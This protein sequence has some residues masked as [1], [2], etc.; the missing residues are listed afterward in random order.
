MRSISPIR[1]LI[2]ILLFIC[3]PDNV[4][5]QASC[6]SP[7]TITP[8]TTCITNTSSRNENIKNATSTSPTGSC[9]GATATT[10]YGEWFIF[11]PVASTATITLSGLGSSLSAATTYIELLTGTC[12]SFT[13]ICQNAS[14]SLNATGLIVGTPYYVRVYVTTN[15]NNG[16]SPNQYDYTICITSPPANDECSGAVSL[17]SNTSCSNTAGSFTMITASTGLP[18]GCEPA[19]T[20]Y[21]LWYSFVAA[22]STHTVTLSSFTAGNPALQLYSGSCGSLTSLACGTTTVSSTSLTA[23]ATYYIRVSNVGT[24]PGSATFNICVTNPSIITGDECT[25]AIN[26]TSNSG[27]INTS[28]TLIGATASSGIPTGC[29][30]AG[31]H[32]DVWF[33][34][35]A[36]RT[37]HTISFTKKNPSNISNSELQ[38]FSGTCGSLTSLQC[39]TTSIAATGLTIATTYYVRVS[40]VGGSALT[41]R[42]DFDICVTHAATAP[43]TIDYSKSYVNITKGTNGGTVDP[44]DTL[45]IRATFVV[46][47]GTGTADSLG[48]FD[49]LTSTEGLRL[50]PGSIALRTNE[51]KVYKSFSDNYDTDAGWRQESANNPLDTAIQI[52]FGANASNVRRGSL[53]NTSRPSV[54]GSTCIIMATYRVVVTAGYNTV[55]NLGG[56]ALTLYNGGNYSDLK[57]NP[58]NVAVYQSPGLCPN[59]VSPTNALGA[60]SNG[61]FGSGTT[62]NRAASPYTTYTYMAFNPAGPNDYY[63]GIANNTSTTGTTVTTWAKPNSNRVHN[64]WDISG[65]HTG[66]SDPL[67]GNLPTAVGSN[68]GY[69]LVINAAYR[70]DTAFTYT[71]TNLCPNTY[72]EL[73]AWFKNI[74]YKCGCDSTGAGTSSGSYIPTALGDSSGVRPNIAFDVNGV[75]YYTTGDILYQGLSGGQT[76]SDAANRWVK[77]GFTYLT[78][79][80]QTSFTLTLRNNA[81]GGGGNDWAL[82]DIAVA[83]C[84]P[85][86]TFTPSAT[87]AVCSGNSVD[88]TST[89]TSYFN[90]YTHYKWQLSTDNGVTWTDA[91]GTN[92]T[93]TGSPV[94]GSGQ[95]QY[96]TPTYSTQVLN[97]GDNIKYRLITATTATNLTTTS[98]I[99][100][101]TTNVQPNILSDC[102]PVLGTS[103]ISFNAKQDGSQTQ[104]RWTTSKET[105]IFKFIIE[106]S[107]DGQNF[108]AIG[109]MYSSGARDNSLNTYTWSESYRQGKYYYR[110]KMTSDYSGTKYSRVGVIDGLSKKVNLAAIV[111]P[112]TSQLTAYVEAPEAGII[113]MQ[114]IDNYGVLVHSQNASLQQGNNRII[115]SDTGKLPSG[116]YTLKL[117]SNQNIISKKLIKQ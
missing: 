103:I 20:H 106:G 80:A 32:Y 41:T 38:L 59:A 107:S 72:Y 82:D 37:S 61:T 40:Q 8:A 53:T 25:S 6:A 56:G 75:D 104:L 70:A 29:A 81:P 117:I 114:L 108:V 99:L 4:Y 24:N 21:D 100:A 96:T 36:S 113:K 111:N 30:S 15:P 3:L 93:G 67:V 2:T 14:S 45:E 88:L 92:S 27:C 19:G 16:G 73:S 102:P 26:L 31:T 91:S 47:S 10:T 77:R 42:G 112:F 54:F 62:Q 110:I 78:G 7:A 74:C 13:S 28:A 98:C 85:N 68:G 52:N 66:A 50:V 51:G 86:L 64:V 33:S 69:M 83:T 1:I 12:G 97:S 89:V 60:E 43:A 79:A 90:N 9:G 115:I 5:S 109:T 44:G 65:D 95:Y 71:I 57:F 105:E 48:F 84:T 39:G 116:M 58:T 18:A 76:G 23:G 55:L 22:T 34:F 46:R 87:P 11:T 63:Y 101:D 94:S 17:T 49:T 35:V